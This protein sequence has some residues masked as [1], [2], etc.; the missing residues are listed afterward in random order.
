MDLHG[1]QR[2]I[3]AESVD[4]H[5]GIL[6]RGDRTDGQGTKVEIVPAADKGAPFR[7]LGAAGG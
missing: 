7:S 4:V 3:L 6:K 2:A 1:R 5:I